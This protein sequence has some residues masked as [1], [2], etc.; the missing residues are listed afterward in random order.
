[1]SRPVA[2]ITGANSGIGYETAAQM[3]E[4]KRHRVVIACR[5]VAKAVDTKMKLVKEVRDA[6]LQDA[7]PCGMDLSDVVSVTR[8]MERLQSLVSVVVLNAAVITFDRRRGSFGVDMTYAT[9][10]FGHH[11]LISKLLER[12]HPL[13]TIVFAG[14]EVSRGDVR[15]VAPYPF[16][17]VMPDFEKACRECLLGKTEMSPITRYATAKLLGT[18]WVRAL[19]RALPSVRVMTVSPGTVSATRITRE[20]SPVVRLIDYACGSCL[21][22]RKHDVREAAGRYLRA[23]YDEEFETGGFYASL[24]GRV[25]GP[26]V[27]Q[28]DG[29]MLASEECTDC[30][31]RVMCEISGSEIR[32]GM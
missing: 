2:L 12:G 26:L 6:A 17:P 16:E 29:R 3:L 4:L 10:L 30:V 24:P 20:L 13:D 11:I 15:G 32:G 14:S 5:S 31:L 22:G 25:S 9:T 18:M 19:S 21:V 27:E 28:V 8:A 7:E 1:M 23:I